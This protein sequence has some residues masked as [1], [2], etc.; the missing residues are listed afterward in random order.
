LLNKDIVI[1]FP[2]IRKFFRISGKIWPRFNI[3][4]KD[5]LL[6]RRIWQ[7]R[8]KSGLPCCHL[9]HHEKS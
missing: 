6:Q 1:F 3:P 2:E 7:S 8:K 4:H 9:V 5:S